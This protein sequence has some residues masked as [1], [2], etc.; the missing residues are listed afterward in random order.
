MKRRSLKLA[1]LNASVED[2]SKR[3]PRTSLRHLSSTLFNLPDLPDLPDLAQQIHD[4]LAQQIF[5]GPLAALSTESTFAD[6]LSVTRDPKAVFAGLVDLVADLRDLPKQTLHTPDP[7]AL[8]EALGS[9]AESVDLP[10]LDPRHPFSGLKLVKSDLVPE[11]HVAILTEPHLDSH[12][13]TTQLPVVLYVC[14]HPDTCTTCRPP[15]EE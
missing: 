7:G 13:S 3:M 11:G 4:D 1:V 14:L 15:G 5:D 8:V 2:L 12:L 10:R 6:S 9:T